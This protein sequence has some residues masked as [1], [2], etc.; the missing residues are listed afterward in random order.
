MMDFD[1]ALATCRALP[2]PD[3]DEQPLREALTRAGL[4]ARTLAWDDP[5]APFDRARRVVIRSTWNYVHH[6]DAFLA[7]VD[8][9][10]ARLINPAPVVRWNVHKS[11]LH[12]LDREGVAVVPTEVVRRGSGRSLGDV[13]ASRAWSHAVVKPAV[14]AASFETRVLRASA[15]DA[16]LVA[17]FAGA[18]E[19]R[20][21][22]VQPYMDSVEGYGERALI[23][24]DGE[25]THAIRKNPRFAGHDECVS[26]DGVAVAD[27]ERA[28]AQSAVRAA[29][30]CVPGEAI[31]YARVD[32]VRDGD[33]LR[34]MELELIEPSLFFA[35]GPRGLERFVRVLG[36][37]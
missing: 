8:R 21:M 7:W 4:S 28:F 25:V 23:W 36:R 18:L 34:V 32:I 37:V 2:E 24:I 10:G 13:L 3:P 12:D 29:R 1:I 27:D 6:L 9:V 31:T 17:W 19:A 30:R 22:L 35:Q 16:S 20:D 15:L 33:G 11:Y 26:S 14:S 5:D